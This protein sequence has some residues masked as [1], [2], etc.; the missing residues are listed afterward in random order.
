VIVLQA[1]GACYS[2]RS[3]PPRRLG[4]SGSVEAR[5][6]LVRGSG[7]DCEGSCARPAGIAKSN[8]S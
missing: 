6:K 5:K 3:P 7:E 4:G 1:G 2:W 8:S